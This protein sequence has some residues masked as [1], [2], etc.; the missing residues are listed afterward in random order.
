MAA[1]QLPTV[2]QDAI[3]D[4]PTDFAAGKITPSRYNSGTYLRG[5]FAPQGRLTLLSATPVLTSTVS[6]AGTVYYTPYAGNGVPIWNGTDFE[7]WDFS[8]LSNVLA[9]SST[10]KAGPAAATTNSNY[11][12]FVWND[13]GTL[14]LTRGPAWTSGTARGTGAGTTELQLVNGLWTN[15]LAITNGPAAG[16]GTYVGTIWTNT[17][18]ATVT[19]S[20]GSLAAGGGQAIIG[21]WNACNRSQVAVMVRDSTTSWS[22]T[23]GTIRPVNNSTNNSCIYVAGL[24]IDFITFQYAFQSFVSTGVNPEAGI[25]V[26]STTAF[27]GTHQFAIQSLDATPAVGCY[28]GMP[29]I[30]KHQI[31]ALEFGSTGSGFYGDPYM[32]LTGVLMA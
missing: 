28:S 2:F 20:F 16:Y 1:R 14:R 18:S 3:A 4:D 17:G 9:N 29:G 26:D 19:M 13:G 5:S 30:G 32:S 7:W 25:G 22:Y 12:L 27:S 11:D 15:K 8:E 24:A 21:L 31:Y 10:G 6:A 23:L